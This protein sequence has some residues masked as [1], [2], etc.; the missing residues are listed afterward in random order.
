MSDAEKEII[1]LLTELRDA[2]Q[3]ELAYRRRVLEESLAQQQ[4]SIA[5]QRKAV[6]WQRGA[7]IAFPLLGVAMLVI[8]LLLLGGGSMAVRQ[9]R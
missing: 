9:P 5:L 6:R 1:R 4:Q 8:L 7:M 2:Q 3:E